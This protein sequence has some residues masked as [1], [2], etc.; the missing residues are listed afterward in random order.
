M[1]EISIFLFIFFRVKVKNKFDRIKIIEIF[2]FSIVIF[3]E[4]KFENK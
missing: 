4:F 2:R 3:I 1:R